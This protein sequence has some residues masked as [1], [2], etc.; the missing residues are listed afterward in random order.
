MDSGVLEC[1]IS[2]HLIVFII[3]KARSPR[4]LIKTIKYRSYKNYSSSNFL[5]DLHDT[6]WENV[7]MCFTVHDAWTSFKDTFIKIADRHAPMSSKRVRSNTLPRIN[8]HIR[9]LMQRK[10]KSQDPLSEMKF[11]LVSGK[12]RRRTILS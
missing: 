5:C 6:S 7:D 12:L 10:L 4:G 2:D 9:G 3:R 11:L 1:S 8:D